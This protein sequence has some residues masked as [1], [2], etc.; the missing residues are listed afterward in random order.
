[1]PRSGCQ[2]EGVRWFGNISGSVGDRC[3]V[4]VLFWEGM[5]HTSTVPLHL[6]SSFQYES[7][8]SFGSMY[9]TRIEG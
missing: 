7:Q 5:Q 2:P 4:W 1:M 9:P 8:T 3:V 6:C